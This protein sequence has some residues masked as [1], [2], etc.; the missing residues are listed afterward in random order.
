MFYNDLSVYEG[1]GGIVFAPEEGRNIA[2][3][4]GPTRKNIILQNHGYVTLVSTMRNI[5]TRLS[6]TFQPTHGWQHR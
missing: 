1:F 4:M 2:N 5:C 6:N 3:A